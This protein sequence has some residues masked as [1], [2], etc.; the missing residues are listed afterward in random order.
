MRNPTKTGVSA[1]GDMPLSLDTS[2]SAGILRKLDGTLRRVERKGR[3]DGRCP[4]P[5]LSG[6]VA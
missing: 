5:A 4:P 3:A 1:E 2:G 6:R